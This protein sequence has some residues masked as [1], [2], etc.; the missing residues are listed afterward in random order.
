MKI[1]IETKDF[2]DKE[3]VL[4]YFFQMCLENPELNKFKV[5]IEGTDKSREK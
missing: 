4:N 3:R 2:E 1:I 5:S